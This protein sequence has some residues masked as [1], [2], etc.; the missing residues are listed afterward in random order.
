M[1][2]MAHTPFAIFGIT[3]LFLL[4]MVPLNSIPQ[5]SEIYVKGT[6]AANTDAL[7]LENSFEK[8]IAMTGSNYIQAS[9]KYVVDNGFV[10]DA[11]SS[12]DFEA[13]EFNGSNVDFVNYT[14]WTSGLKTSYSERGHNLEY[15]F[16]NPSLDTGLR[17]NGSVDIDYNFTHDSRSTTYSLDSQI[18]GLEGLRGPDPLLEDASGGSFGPQY[19]YCGFDTP[20]IQL[21]I[22][23][24]S[25]G[26]I[27]HGYASV[28]PESLGSVDNSYPRVL[29]VDNVSGYTSGQLDPF[30]GVVTDQGSI[31]NGNYAEIEGLNLNVT[32]G[33]SLIINS[34]EAWKSYFRVIM[35]ERCYISNSNAPGVLKRMEGSFSSSS[36]GLTTFVNDSSPAGTTNEAYIFHDSTTVSPVN[37]SGVTKGDYGNFRPYFMLSDDSG[38]NNIA[39][40]SIA[41]LVN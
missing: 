20:A 40:W 28:E 4:F 38:D 8:G 26:E 33:T 16:E 19:R 18:S 35:D 13:G 1:K 14:E 7:L 3:V 10:S 17:V 29:V 36:K 9:N 32:E 11:S 37:I 30:T 6:E 21:G 23:S 31:P 15:R 39:E 2:G 25:S 27:A 41:N 5:E 22:G 12:I 34:D 24:S